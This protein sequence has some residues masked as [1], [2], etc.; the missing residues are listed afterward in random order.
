VLRRVRFEVPAGGFGEG[1]ESATLD[2]TYFDLGEVVE[3][4]IPLELV[5]VSG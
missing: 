4:G 2:V 1:T 3:L 5:D